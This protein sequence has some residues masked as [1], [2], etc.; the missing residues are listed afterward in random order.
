MIEKNKVMSTFVFVNFKVVAKFQNVSGEA[1]FLG[2]ILQNNV[3][4]F[5][6]S[7]L[8]LPSSP[9]YWKRVTTTTLN[10]EDNTLLEGAE[11]SGIHVEGE[12]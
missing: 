9:V 12:M 1:G 5:F 8:Q 11:G 7:I 3:T 2:K 10:A 6:D 4:G